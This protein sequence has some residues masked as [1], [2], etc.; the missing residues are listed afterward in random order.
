MASKKAKKEVEAPPPAEE[1]E[2]VEE[3]EQEEKPAP[4][5]YELGKGSTPV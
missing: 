4:V 1:P 2:K 3:V 5:V